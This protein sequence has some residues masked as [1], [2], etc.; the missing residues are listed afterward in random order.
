M[1]TLSKKFNQLSLLFICLGGLSSGCSSQPQISK[2]PSVEPTATIAV[3]TSPVIATPTPSPQVSSATQS[4]GDIYQEALTK[5]EA[6]EAIAQSAA[7]KDDWLLVA[8]NLKTSIDLLQSISSGS[9]QRINAAKVLPKYEQKLAIAKQKA[10]N[11]IPKPIP[12]LASSKQES[13]STPNTENSNSFSIPIEKKLGG[14]P[15]IRVTFNDT[16]QVPMLLDTGAS[17]SLIPKSIADRMQLKIVGT[18]KAKTANGMG[19]F[20]VAKVDRVKFGAGTTE[21]V[22]IAIADNGLDYGLLGHDVYDGYDITIKESS[23]E[24]RKR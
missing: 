7:S 18:A 12:K 1:N 11:F 22:L 8:S 23:I 10:I 9:P 17:R 15:V 5:A 2:T 6:A 13:S 3:E 20:S 4:D 21:G 24:F 16:P 14:I 19:S